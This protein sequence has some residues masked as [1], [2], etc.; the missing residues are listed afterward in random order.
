MA[1]LTGVQVFDVYRFIIDSSQSKLFSAWVVL[2]DLI[3]QPISETSACGEYLKDNKV[4]YRA[5]RNS[6]NQAQSS[7]RQL[8]EY[9]GSAVDDELTAKNIENWNTLAKACKDCLTNRSKDIEVFG[10]FITA[11]LFGAN[12]LSNMLLAC[13][14]LALVIDTYWDDLHPKPTIDKLKAV[15]DAAR[16]I[17]WAELKVKPMWQFAGET[18]GA[19]VLAMQLSNLPL[20]GTISYSQFYTA[21]RSGVLA[22]LKEQASEIFS[23]EK[24]A[25]TKIVL[26]LSDVKISIEHI[27]ASVNQ[28]CSQVSAKGIS[29]KFL[30]KLVEDLL[31]AI[32]HL[33]GDSFVVWPLK[34]E[35]IIQPDEQPIGITNHHTQS[36]LS[37]AALL[38]STLPKRVAIAAGEVLFN[39]DQAF[40]E[41]R[42]ISEYFNQTEPH[43]PVHMLLERAIR[44][45][46]ISLPELLKEMV[47]ENLEVMGRI[48]QMVGLENELKAFVPAP[49]V[50]VAELE[51]H[52]KANLYKVSGL[53]PEA[54]GSVEMVA[55]KPSVKEGKDELSG[56]GITNFQW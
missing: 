8:M 41:L 50:S 33:F 52:H 54:A 56:A 5:L 1:S 29:F 23:V 39:R 3:A 12:P 17:E 44:W 10:W 28:R 15:D 4:L 49:S 19:G 25:I 48:N 2:M 32:K 55:T 18:Q 43:S 26:I 37:D 34:I 46:Y 20:A 31:S 47:G 21:E 27:E 45:G 36:D 16:N 30:V 11:Q 38:E 51:Q 9:P 24:D 53:E 14:T 6:F 13:N 7:Y 42:K 22:E 40:T 35:K